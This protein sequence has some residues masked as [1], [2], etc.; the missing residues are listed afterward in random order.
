MGVHKNTQVQL[1]DLPA[2]IAQD[3]KESYIWGSIRII[4]AQKHLFVQRH[5][6]KLLLIGRVEG[7][8]ILV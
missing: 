8:P 4:R 7:L 1:E 2:V 3:I 6:P 5:Q